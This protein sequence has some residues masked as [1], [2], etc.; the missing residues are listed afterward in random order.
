M[1]PVRAANIATRKPT[2]GQKAGA[3]SAAGP[4]ICVISFTAMT[5]TLHDA[6]R[7]RRP[8]R[9]EKHGTP[10]DRNV[11]TNGPDFIS[12]IIRTLLVT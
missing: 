1:L 3:G 10:A 7:V 5:V 8:A 2:S 9:S 11:R 4:D 6:R 12:D